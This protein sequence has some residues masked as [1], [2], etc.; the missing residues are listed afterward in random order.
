MKTITTPPPLILAAL[1]ACAF[2]ACNNNS[3]SISEAMK[4][5][6]LKRGNIISCSPSGEQFGAVEFE[7]SCSPK[8]QKDFDLGIALLHSFEYDEAEKAFAKVVDAEPETAIAWWGV[9]M[10]N[11]HPLWAPPTPAELVKGAK[12]I[13]IAQS[14]S[15][16]SARESAYIEAMAAFYKDNDHAT[17]CRN[18]EQAMDKLHADYP[19]DKEAA[20]FYALALNGAADPTDKTFSKQKKAGEILSAL[21]AVDHPGIVHYIIHSYDYPSLAELALPAARKYASVAPASAHA[22][23]MPS[24]I[25]TRLGLWNEDIQSNLAAASSAKCYAE[26]NGIKGHWDEELHA[27]DYLVYSYLQKGDNKRA[28]EQ[29]D[30]LLAMQK[31]SPVNFKVAYAFAAIPARYMMENRMWTAAAALEPPSSHIVAWEKYPWQKSI[32]HFARLLGNV[33]TGRLDVAKE[34][35]K[36]MNVLYDTL[37]DQKDVYKANQVQIQIKSGEAWIL[38]KEGKSDD[39]LKLMAAAA[40]MEERTQKH[41][42]TPGEVLPARELYADMLMELNRPNDALMAYEA[43]LKEHANR[44]NGLYGAALAAQKSNNTEKAT[45]YYKQLVAITDS[46]NSRMELSAAKAYLKKELH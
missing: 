31:V 16:K 39:A 1:F 21:S 37:M 18:F 45:S 15:K 30:S 32:I 20:I 8:A 14:L 5:I 13:A 38:L 35:L 41:P 25:F 23:H 10:S 12:A 34:E 19:N 3:A 6:D 36:T 43:D 46:T 27:I 24:H 28:K 33:H 42:V 44:F 17:R 7:T 11:F 29:Y 22:Q 4:A 40:T 26:S 2:T 9:A